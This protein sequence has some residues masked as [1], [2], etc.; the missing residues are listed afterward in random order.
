MPMSFFVAPTTPYIPKII[1]RPFLIKNTPNA[2]S[3]HLVDL[4]A[5]TMNRPSGVLKK[6][7][8]SEQPALTRVTVPRTI[9]GRPNAARTFDQLT[10]VAFGRFLFSAAKALVV[11][12]G[13]LAVL[14]LALGVAAVDKFDP[15][16][17]APEALEKPEQNATAPSL[18]KIET[19]NIAT[20]AP[21]PET[22]PAKPILIKTKRP[23]SMRRALV[24]FA[25]ASLA[26]VLPLQGLN[27]WHAIETV[28]TRAENANTTAL[29]V[30]NGTSS[31]A[32]A[33]TAI[34]A[35]RQSVTDLGHVA[36]A[37]LENA[38]QVGGMF[39]S[40]KELLDAGSNLATAAALLTRSLDFVNNPSLDLTTKLARAEDLA[41]QAQPLLTQAQTELNGADALPAGV[42]GSLGSLRDKVSATNDLVNAFI[43]IAPSLRS[44]LG[45]TQ[46]R[47][48][49][50]IFQNNA[51]LRPTGGFIGSFAL[52]DVDRGAIKAVEVPAGGSYDLQGSLKASVLSPDP[53]RLV[54]A[55][56][57]FQ[58]ANWFPDFPT[59]AKKLTW[60]YNQS[61]G[62]SVDGVIALNAPILANLLDAV[63][64]I[65]MPAYGITATSTTVLQTAQEIVESPTA[66]ASGKPKQFI[67]DLMPL[68]LQKIM[69]GGGDQAVRTLG[70]FTK[71]L[72]EKDIQM[73]FSDDSEEQ[74]FDELGW[75]GHIDPLP[76]GFDSFE[77]VRANI[78]GAKTDAV[79]AAKIDHASVVA[80]DGSITDHVTVTLTHN[81]HKGDQFT[82]VRN[83]TYLRLYVPEGS[84]LIKAGGDIR[85]PAPSFF[86]TPPE[87]CSPDKT[88]ADVT[89]VVLHDPMSGTAINN[90]FGRTVYGVWTQTDPGASSTVSFD[91]TLPFAVNPVA[92][93]PNLAQQFGLAA[94]TAPSAPFGLIM[95]KQS[96]AGA[97]EISSSLKLPAGWYPS[98]ASPEGIAAPDGWNYTSDLS[99]DKVIGAIISK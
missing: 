95:N 52:V 51:E 36:N 89:G 76:Q 42:E 13:K 8:K 37:L 75:T 7:T 84:K 15:D 85:P 71:A 88:L 50:V 58:D 81:G 40:G 19:P 35:A 11:G 55:K 23:F 10:V 64:P 26:I 48:Y 5:I 86:D 18:E 53:L 27:A 30:L 54:R 91:Y 78:A 4:R 17:I 74:A 31:L 43:K 28:K 38:P 3:P 16:R 65:N 25:G 47:R 45:E 66:R 70:I 93:A 98:F 59:S 46:T 1:A 20:Y 2:P 21:K 73:S 29:G 33:Q 77:L 83:V 61:S 32:D 90:E 87:G 94:V 82:G 41:Q 68:V 97:T 79:M 56:W 96:G 57:E 69:S 24:S 80:D 67:A 60:F 6:K 62:P 12:A 63:G 9:S 34:T 39:R 92:P 72:Q 22:E 99:T 44:I 49:L 14:P